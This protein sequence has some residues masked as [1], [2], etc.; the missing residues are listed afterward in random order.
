MFFHSELVQ[1]CEL[2]IR[3]IREMLAVYHVSIQRYSPATGEWHSQL[4]TEAAPTSSFLSLID[5]LDGDQPTEISGELTAIM[6]Q[7][8][9]NREVVAFK[10]IAKM[11]VVAVKGECLL[12]PITCQ[13]VVWGRICIIGNTA[14]WQLRDFDWLQV[15]AKVLGQSIF[16]IYQLQVPQVIQDRSDV[17]DPT[18]SDYPQGDSEESVE[19]LHSQLSEL[20]HRDQAKDEFISKIS[21]DLRAPLMNMRMALKMLKISIDQD[22][23]IAMLFTN[24]RTLGYWNILEA[25]CEREINLVNNVLDLQKIETGNTQLQMNEINMTDWLTEIAAPYQSRAAEHQ[26]QIQLRLPNQPAP[27]V[28]DEGC[29]QRIISELFHNACKYTAIGQ[30]IICELE[31]PQSVP[32]VGVLATTAHSNGNGNGYPTPLAP[33]NPLSS[34]TMPLYLTI[35]NQATVEAA[36]LP[37]LFDRFYRVP[38]ADH[39]R[40]GGTGLGLSLVRDLV[41]Q[42]HGQITVQ[43]GGGWT[44]FT[45]ALPLSPPH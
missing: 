29:L 43:S 39:H 19:I 26:Q 16:T 23:S 1:I 5:G 6:G 27:I 7:R 32:L 13:N 4:P 15:L 22:P 17:T 33:T 38:A 45:V 14:V 42:L 30:E 10:I 34:N 36:D 40:Q 37:H 24:Q 20:V 8:L 11:G 3:Q 31:Y 21:H 28:T 35:S 9:R 12:L 25:E 2:T 44:T 18:P 41:E